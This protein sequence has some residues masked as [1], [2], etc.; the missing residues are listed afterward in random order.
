MTLAE[1]TKEVKHRLI[2]MDDTVAHM[3]RE[4]GITTQY[5]YQTLGGKEPRQCMVDRI[6]NY[7]GIEPIKL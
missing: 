1:W 2:D 4:L 6:S 7:V 5:V 3:S